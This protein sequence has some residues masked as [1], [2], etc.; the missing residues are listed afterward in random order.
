MSSKSK[1]SRKAIDR[2][3]D[4]KL[5]KQAKEIASGYQIIIQ[6]QDGEYYG[7]GLE[8]PY[9]MN[10]GITPDACVAATRESLTT[11]IAHLLETG[12]KPPAPASDQKRSEQVNIRL[13]AEEKLLLD[14]AARCRGFK[15][16]GDFVRSTTLAT[17]R[18]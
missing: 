6:Y 8:L 11:A 16:I 12:E 17:I 14:E 13:T 15:G 3:F 9:V 18:Y 7:R 2:P 1:N 10:D 4:A 5:L